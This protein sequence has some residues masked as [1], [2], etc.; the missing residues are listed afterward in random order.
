[1]ISNNTYCILHLKAEKV[2]D[3]GKTNGMK[4]VL[5]AIFSQMLLTKRG[6]WDIIL[7]K[8]MMEKSNRGSVS[9]ERDTW[10]KS[11][12]RKNGEFRSGDSC[13]VSMAQTCVKGKELNTRWHRVYTP[14]K[15]YF[16][17]L[18]GGVIFLR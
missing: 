11:F 8:S 18:S 7:L 9:R 5:I 3:F 12:K 13:E 16:L 2:N 1:M 14:L 6:L 4:R 15:S 10:C 17:G